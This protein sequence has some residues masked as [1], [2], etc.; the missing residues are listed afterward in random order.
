MSSSS[1]SRTVSGR[2]PDLT[3]RSGF[4]VVADPLLGDG[5]WAAVGVLPAPALF[6]VR[7]R[8][9]WVLGDSPLAS[10]ASGGG[11]VSNQDGGSCGAGSPLTFIGVLARRQPKRLPSTPRPRFREVVQ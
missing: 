6:V 11:T 2:S 10:S 4:D 3:T 9:F 7:A 8:A 5:L 1:R